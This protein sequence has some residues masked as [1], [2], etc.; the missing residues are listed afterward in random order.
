MIRK[1]P[2]VFNGYAVVPKPGTKRWLAE[3]KAFCKDDN[4]QFRC[5]V[6]LDVTLTKD[7]GADDMPGACSTCWVKAHPVKSKS[8]Y[9]KSQESIDAAQL[10]ILE[11]DNATARRHYSEAAIYQQEFV[12]RLRPSQVKT[13][14]VYKESIAT[15]LRRACS[16]GAS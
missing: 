2:R 9:M 15:L 3:E 14:A 5:D 11:G 16:L 1:E 6:C 7:G 8:P 10:A 12:D 4:R 13:R